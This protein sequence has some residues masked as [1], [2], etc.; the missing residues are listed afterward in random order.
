M[1]A[2]RNVLE[3]TRRQPLAAIFVGSIAVLAAAFTL[4]PKMTGGQVPGPYAPSPEHGVR[5][6]GI[7]GNRPVKS[8]GSA[9]GTESATGPEIG[10]TKQDAKGKV[11]L[12]HIPRTL[13]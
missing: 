8:T 11:S 1:Q 13:F 10:D 12:R 3:T 5:T 2:V 6:G 4:P 7:I 9:S